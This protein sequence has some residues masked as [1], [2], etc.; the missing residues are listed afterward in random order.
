LGE[1]E[2]EE[3]K[4]EICGRFTLMGLGAIIHIA[5]ITILVNRD[6]G[7]FSSSD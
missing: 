3:N 7:Q 5:A 4:E 6:P 2:E 1:Q